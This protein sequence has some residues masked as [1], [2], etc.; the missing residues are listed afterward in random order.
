MN[1]IENEFDARAKTWDMDADKINRAQKVGD[2]ILNEVKNMQLCSALEYGCGTGL[3]SLHLRAHFSKIVCAD[4]SKSM[5]DVLRE[6]INKETISNVFPLELDLM[7]SSPIDEKFDIIYTLL[8]LH[9]VIDTDK[10]LSS[11][12]SMINQGG[13]LFIA[14]LDKED[15]SFHGKGFDGHNG[16]DRD[17]LKLKAIKVGFRNIKIET[18]TEVIK[19][20]SGGDKKAFPLFLMTAEK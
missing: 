17:Q 6:K 18:V 10:I 12:Y 1:K 3:V 5:L 13:Y 14:D 16:F 15:G 9:H 20:I 11:F 7:N 2:A 8:T 19:E 4:S